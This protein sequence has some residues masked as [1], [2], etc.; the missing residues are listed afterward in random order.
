MPKT[1]IVSNRL[2]LQVSIKN[3]NLEVSASVGGLATGLKPLHE[4]GDSVWIGWTGIVE[5][6]VPENYLKDELIEAAILKRC[7]PVSLSR[8]EINYFYSGYSNRTLWPLFHYFTE[9]TEHNE[10]FWSYYKSV[11]KKYA[12][13]ILQHAEDGD[14]IWVQDYQLMLVPNYLKEKNKNLT[15]GFFLHIPFPS[16]EVFRLLPE[17]EK[18]LEGVLGADLVGFHTLDYKKHFLHSVK[19]LLSCKVLHNHIT[20]KGRWT[21]ADYFPL[22]IDVEKFE[23]TA[24]EIKNQSESEISEFQKELNNYKNSND[25]VKLIL[26]IDR[27]DYTKG[28]ALRIRAFGYFLERYPKYRGKV[29]LLMLTV[30]S[31]TNVPQYKLLKKEVDELVGNINGK[32]GNI[33]W[34]PIIYFFRSMPFKNLVELYSSSEIAMLTPLRDGMNLVAKEYIASLT[35]KSGVLILSEMTGAAK[36]MQEAIL[37]NP[38]NIEEVA[39]ALICAIEMPEREKI[40][41]NTL[42]Q[43]RLK[44]YTVTTWSDDFMGS[45]NEMKE[46]KVSGAKAKKMGF[47]NFEEV[48]NR[49]N[50]AQSCSFFLDF[51][52]LFKDDEVINSKAGSLRDLIKKIADNMK[53]NVIVVSG[54]ERE[55]LENYW[56]N[57]DLTLIA[58]HGQYIKRG[59]SKWKSLQEVCDRKWMHEFRSI[60]DDYVKKVPGAYIEVKKHSLV[61]HYNSAKKT[62]STAT[63]KELA[64]KLRDSSGLD[65]EIVEGQESLEVIYETNCNKAYSTAFLREITVGELVISIGNGS[66][67]KGLFKNLPPDSVTIRIGTQDSYAKYYMQNIEEVKGFLNKI[68]TDKDLV[69]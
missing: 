24:A 47:E 23:K 37:I 21:K 43:E 49:Y 57:H 9:Y 42:L 36:Q 32:F 44:E 16:Y 48:Y 34:T 39:N 12:E 69:I 55:I 19:E 66:V 20:Y 10:T 62:I 53:N 50:E 45:L 18:L 54:K 52:A 26:S 63:V 38:T 14:T 28:I 6:D 7:I 67:N 29:T 51:D 59:K 60:M 27:M 33:S 61:W 17:R 3:K 30:P 56:Q 35:D 46:A 65:I 5:E 2:P 4:K 22:G 11:N 68:A 58:G 64:T 25:G 31:R 13:E 40:Q 41:R 15:I 1:I 8:Q